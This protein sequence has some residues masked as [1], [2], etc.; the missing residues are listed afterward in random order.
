MYAARPLILALTHG[1]LWK[2]S[3]YFTQTLLP[4]FVEEHPELTSGWDVV[5]DAR[6]HFTEPHT[7]ELF[8]LG[9]LEVRRYMRTWVTLLSGSVIVPPALPYAAETSG[10]FARYHHALFIEKEGFNPLLEQA[11]IARKYDLALMSTKGM[12]VTA[13]RQLVEGLTRAG[14]TIL[15][16]HDFDK[17]GLEILDKFTANTR[18]YTYT[19]QPQVID[20]GLRL[21]EAQA[22]GLQSEPV[23]YNSKIN[24]RINLRA[25]GA[26]EEECAFLVHR[27]EY[28][29]YWEGERIELN[30]MTSQQFLDWLEAQLQA[31]GA[32]KVVPDAS[33]LVTAYQHMAQVALLQRAIDK[34]WRALANLE[35]FRVP[36][37]LEARI[38]EA[39]TDTTTPWDDALWD[40]VC[41]EVPE[42][43]A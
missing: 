22:M 3:D 41:D 34:A 13:A 19:T 8:G 38:R 4:D 42:D 30:A 24:P 10:P 12:S 29:Q 31:V 37:G 36:E 23:M 26:T 17:A 7:G 15:V 2:N 43:D 6:G 28:G 39:I 18:R 33:T 1:R 9:T 35:T 16:V 32:Q 5:F 25:C 11:Q 40:I 21:R 27:C 20:L 14:V